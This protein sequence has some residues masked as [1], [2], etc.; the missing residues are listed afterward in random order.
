[1]KRSPI[2]R[3]T[4]LRRVSKKRK[5]EARVYAVRRKAFLA[6]HPF[7]WFDFCPNASR[8]VHH[9]KGR[10]GGNYLNED[11][12]MAVC[13]KHHNWIHAHPDIARQMTLL[14]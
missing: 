8:D 11:T 1:M 12:W 10:L 7:C 2:K 14:K 4:P 13:R 3:K 9:K 6:S 5:K